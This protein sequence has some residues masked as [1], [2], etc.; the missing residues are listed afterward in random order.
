MDLSVVDDRDTSYV[1]AAWRVVEVCSEESRSQRTA[2]L[3]RSSLIATCMVS[4]LPEHLHRASSGLR[5]VTTIWWSTNAESS[6]ESV[7]IGAARFSNVTRDQKSKSVWAEL[8][9]LMSPLQN[10]TRTPLREGDWL[11]WLCPSGYQLTVDRRKTGL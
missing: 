3:S 7:L 9:Q 10:L 11:T 8:V 6:M 1:A 5:E 2:T 4:E